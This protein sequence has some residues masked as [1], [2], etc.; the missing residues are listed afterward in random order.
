ILV[1]H[2]I[3]FGLIEILLQD[4]KIQDILI[5]SPPSS[6]PVFIKHNDFDE[7]SSNIF[8]SNEELESWASKFRMISGRALDEAH[9]ILDCALN[10]NKMSARVAIVQKP[11]S[12]HGISY[13]IR[14]HRDNPWTLPLFIKNKT[15]NSLAAGLLSF[16][17]DGGR[18]LLIAGTR[19]SGKTSLL[20]SLILEIMPKYRIISVEDTPELPLDSMREL[21]YDVLSMK[22]RSALTGESNEVSAE[23]GIRASLR[24]GDSALIVGEIRSDEAKVL[25]EAMRVGALANVVAGT[26]HGASP[27][28]VFDRVV[29]DLNVPLTSFKA[30]DAIIVVNPIKSPDGIKSWRRLLQI[31]EVRKHWTRDPLEEGGFVDLMKYDV[32]KDELFPTDELINGESEIIKDIASRVKGWAGDWD[33]VW[34]NISLRKQIKE[35]IVYLS[36]KLKKPQMLEAPFCFKAN[37]SFHIISEKVREEFGIPVS[38]E[39]FPKWKEWLEE[40][41]KKI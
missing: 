29:N 17:V 27:Y 7:C 4:E 33:A 35:E 38:K 28:A 30:T 40:E 12:L 3:G 25:Y 5:N 32:E 41:A 8:V 36:E 31:S 23:E 1:R 39:V 9:P 24:L 13:A 15:I 16:L 18:T 21:G 37:N 34:D 6:S 19:S 10:L 20:S 11:L 22:V 2:T 26:I 14:R